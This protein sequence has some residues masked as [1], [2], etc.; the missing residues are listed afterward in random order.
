MTESSEADGDA[1]E[2]V[3]CFWFAEGNDELWFEASDAFDRAVRRALADDHER[4]AAGAYETWRGT[5]R[6]CLAL[7]LLLDQVP[8]NLFRG[9]PRAFATDAQARAIARQAIDRGFDLE[10]AEL[11]QRRFFYL[12]LEH[13]EELADQEDGCRLMAALGGDPKWLQW[14]VKH[15]DVI[16]RFGRFPHRNAVLGRASSAEEIAFLERP[17]SAF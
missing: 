4:A 10:N 12:P 17:D 8:R 9:D 15:R 2:R 7:V 16:A 13:S 5:A 3:L 6:G 14:A 11:V 1:I